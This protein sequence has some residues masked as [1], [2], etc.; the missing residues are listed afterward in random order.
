LAALNRTLHIMAIVQ[1]RNPTEGRAMRV[2]EP[3]IREIAWWAVGF[4]AAP[5]HMQPH[6]PDTVRFATR[7]EG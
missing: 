5:P 1:L 2:H 7:S 6:D 4:R 3:L